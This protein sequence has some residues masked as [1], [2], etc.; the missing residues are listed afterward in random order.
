[1]SKYSETHKYSDFVNETMMS[2][3]ISFTGLVDTP[4]VYEDGKYL[5]ANSGSIV[6]ATVSGGSGGSYEDIYTPTSGHIGLGDQAS[7]KVDINT[8][9]DI[10]ILAST[11]TDY[12]KLD[13]VGAGEYENVGM[14]YTAND[15]NV[16]DVREHGQQL[17]NDNDDKSKV[18]LGQTT[19]T[20]RTLNSRSFT[21]NSESGEYNQAFSIYDNGAVA[22]F[23]A[24]SG[25]KL[26]N[27]TWINEFSIDTRLTGDSDNALPTEKAVKTYVDAYRYRPF[28]ITVFESNENV[29]TG[30]G[31]VGICMP[32]EIDGLHFMSMTASVHTPGTGGEFENTEIQIR[33]YSAGSNYDMLDVECTIDVGEYSSVTAGVSYN[34]DDSMGVYTISEGD[35]I[36]VDVNTVTTT[37]PKGLFVAVAF[38]SDT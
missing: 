29:T 38:R 23:N 13:G 26:A 37:P 25:M 21:I 1:M 7:T 34:I 14:I 9:T 31:V 22:V 36:F 35:V 27:G 24:D 32:A 16:M 8:N 12:L 5:K 33:R 18:I 6:W 17:G 2:G 11:S 10:A 20:L 3:I 28:S 19:A 4:G 30:S 15:I